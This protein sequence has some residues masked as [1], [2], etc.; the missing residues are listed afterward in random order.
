MFFSLFKLYKEANVR[1]QASIMD[2]EMLRE[3]S[4]DSQDKY[5]IEKSQIYLG[6]KIFWIIKLFLNG[7]K[8]PQ[9]EIKDTKWNCYI[10]DLIEFLSNVDILKVL[11]DIDPETFF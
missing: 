7:K 3:A 8:F 10:H 6:Y 2:L 9:G 1:N 11:L 4:Y 5:L